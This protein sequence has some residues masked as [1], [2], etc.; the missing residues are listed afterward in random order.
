MSDLWGRKLVLLLSIVGTCVS[1]SLL[2]FAENEFWFILSRVIVG[3]LKNTETSCYSI[4]TD[5]SSPAQRVKRMAYIGSAIGLGFIIGPALSGVLTSHYSLQMPAYV[6]AVLLA[7]NGLVT[8]LL[9]P[10]TLGLRSLAESRA[11]EKTAVVLPSSEK[12]GLSHH[13]HTPEMK[14]LNDEV[15]D[16]MDAPVEILNSSAELNRPPEDEESLAGRAVNSPANH[17]PRGAKTVTQNEE[18][19]SLWKLLRMPGPLRSLVWVYFGTSLATT[20]F[21]GSNSLLLQYL[22]LSV[23]ASS[24]MISFS[25]LLTV[26]SSF[27]ITYLSNLYSEGQLLLKSLFI[28]SATLFVTAL[29]LLQVMS[30]D[31]GAAT[32]ASVV[33]SGLLIA[34]IP[35]ILSSRTLKSCLLGCVTH[36]SPAS[37]TGT[38]I[39]VL[40]S[41]ESLSRA[42]TP[43]LG[44]FLMDSV[45][46]GGPALA[47]GAIAFAYALWV[48]KYP[49]NP[50]ETKPFV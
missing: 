13:R 3:L 47:G 42:L 18:Q 38:I 15:L 10:E 44:G 41:V 31:S 2:L 25:G 24:W 48:A 22:G 1:Y 36:L 5:I 27:V 16:E 33:V 50:L 30:Y 49:F 28:I 20:I 9:L 40:N 17:T 29:M 45:H 23:Q 35:L 4:I 19:V 21:L 14:N 8:L 32:V 26:L 43:L 34:Y 6:S 11:V 7:L 12:D 39:G 37:Q 46:A